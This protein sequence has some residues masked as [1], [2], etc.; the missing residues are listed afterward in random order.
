MGAPAQD[1]FG[2]D[3][4]G[5]DRLAQAHAIGQQQARA[6]HV[7]RAQ[8]GDKLIRLH[9]HAAG[10]GG[11]QGARPGRAIQQMGDVIQPPGGDRGGIVVTE[12]GAD[13]RHI[14]PRVQQV[15]FQPQKIARGAAQAQ[16]GLGAA[17]FGFQHIPCQPAGAQLDPRRK[18]HSGSTEAMAGGQGTIA[19]LRN[20]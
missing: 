11:K 9:R 1:Q 19:T 16:A 15:P 8:D 5:L 13:R 10:M 20:G 17:G 14:L 7:Q 2:G 18:M 3:H 12:V 6:R 4:A